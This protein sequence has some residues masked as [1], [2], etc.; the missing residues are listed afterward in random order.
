MG[1]AFVPRYPLVP[2]E[3]GP[4]A[5]GRHAEEGAVVTQTESL[6]IPCNG[7]PAERDISGASWPLVERQTWRVMVNGMVVLDSSD[8]LPN[9]GPGEALEVVLTSPLDGTHIVET[10]RVRPLLSEAEY[11]DRHRELRAGMDC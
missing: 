8:E 7:N 3:S 4:R 11:R 2:G 9:P 10:A 5:S 6:K 1:P